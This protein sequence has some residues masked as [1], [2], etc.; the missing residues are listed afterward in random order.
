MKRFTPVVVVAAVAVGCAIVGLATTRGRRRMKRVRRIVDGLA[1]QCGTPTAKL[2]LLADAMVGDMHAALSSSD[3]GKSTLRMLHSPHS[4]LPIGNEEGLFYGMDFGDTHIRFVRVKLGGK[5]GRVL[6]KQSIDIPVPSKLMVGSS[7]VG[8]DVLLELNEALEK[9]GVAM[10]VSTLVNDA[11]GAL[12]GG[13]YSSS[14][15]V[16]SVILGMGTNAGYI[17]NAYAIPKWQGSLVKAEEMIINM[18]WGNFCSSHLPITE[19]DVCLDA[20]GPNRDEK[21]YE[22]LVSG[23]YLGDIVRRVLLKLAK[24]TA[25]LGNII[26]PKLMIPFSLRTPDVASMH[27]DTSQDLELVG[28]KMKEFGVP[29]SSLMS[30]EIVVEVC[31]IIARRSA[32]LAAAGIV[33]ILKKL[34]RDGTHQRSV[35]VVDGGLYEHYRLYRDYLHEAVKEMLHGKL[36]NNVIIKHDECGIGAALLP[37]TH[38]M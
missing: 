38:S 10:R 35:V 13:R 15:T 1:Q 27:Q 5:Y 21:V 29:D 2:W 25:L 34:G 31:D 8:K 16:A 12:V 3:G 14:D 23:M 24:E 4:S 18:E 19:F 30:R 17:E 26:P 28:E 37:A 36:S 7:Q 11:V 9:H 20:E 32:R 33:G 22:K 6:D